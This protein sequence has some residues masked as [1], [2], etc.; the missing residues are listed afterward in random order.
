MGGTYPA[1]DPGMAAERRDEVDER[2]PGRIPATLADVCMRCWLG[3]RRWALCWRRAAL[4]GRLRAGFFLPLPL[5][6]R[7]GVC[8][9]DMAP[10][11]RPLSEPCLGGSSWTSRSECMAV[12]DKP[13]PDRAG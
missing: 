10:L 3:R 5:R 1:T 8:R 11:R 6:A 12:G 4:A 7:M 2:V 13:E 9:A